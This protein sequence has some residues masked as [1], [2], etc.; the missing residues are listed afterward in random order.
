MLDLVEHM[1][2][3]GMQY[4]ISVHRKPQPPHELLTPCGGTHADHLRDIQ[5]S[6][7]PP[8]PCTKNDVALKSKGMQKKVQDIPGRF[9]DY[10]PRGEATQETAMRHETPTHSRS[11]RGTPA[12]AAPC[13]LL[14]S[15]STLAATETFKRP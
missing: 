2:L 13:C 7:P 6:S 8:P 15:D 1:P 10:W 12:G 4:D 11:L 3:H 14:G 9:V 5:S